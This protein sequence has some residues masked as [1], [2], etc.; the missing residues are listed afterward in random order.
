MAN[1]TFDALNNTLT[2]S[3]SFAKKASKIGSPEY[4]TILKLRKDFP[5][6]KIVKKEGKSGLCYAQME[7]FMKMHRNSKELRETFERVKKLSRIQPMPYKY[8]K[9]WFD[10]RFPYYSDE[11]NFDKDGYVV[12][13]NTAV[14]AIKMMKDVAQ[15]NNSDFVS[16]EGAVA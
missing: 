7:D 11:P 6:L 9:S 13:P 8:V 14:E 10:N 2:I 5:E 3:A 4:N 12:A 16:A 1:Y 15:A